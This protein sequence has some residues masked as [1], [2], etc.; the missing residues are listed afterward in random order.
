MAFADLQALFLADSQIIFDEFGQPLTVGTDAVTGIATEL[1]EQ[2]VYEDEGR[3]YHLRYSVYCRPSDF[4]TEPKE[5]DLCTFNG[6]EYRIFRIAK[7]PAQVYWRLD[8]GEK[9]GRPI[10][11]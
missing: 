10:E 4:T 9:Y 6:K 7:G 5:N 2:I 3:M 1:E 11:L 8:I